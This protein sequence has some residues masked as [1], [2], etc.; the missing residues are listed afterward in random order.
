MGNQQRKSIKPKANYLKRW[1]KSIKPLARFLKRIQITNTKTERKCITT[2][3]T[4]INELLNKYY[5]QLNTQKFDNVDEM[6][7][8]L[9]RHNLPKLTQEEIDNLN[10]LI[11]IKGIKQI[12]FQNGKFQ[13]H[14]G[15]LVNFTKTLM[16]TL[17]HFPRMSS[18]R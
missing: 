7:Q 18:R 6:H 4:N 12:T 10:R 17:C 14:M 13:S 11:S 8:L 5:K 3:P 2:D 9:E 1:I 15:S 16:K